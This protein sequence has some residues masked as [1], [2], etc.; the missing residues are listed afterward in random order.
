LTTSSTAIFVPFTTCELFQDG[1]ALYYGLNALSNNLIMA[2]RKSL[3]NPKG[4]CSTGRIWT[5]ENLQA[6]R[7][8]SAYGQ[9]QGVK[10]MYKKEVLIF[11]NSRPKNSITWGWNHAA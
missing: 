4:L 10:A 6:E 9:P 11:Y 3:K 8:F 5:S 1:E 2:N 7:A